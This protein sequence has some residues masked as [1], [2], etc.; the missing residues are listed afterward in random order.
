MQK[1]DKYFKG[2]SYVYHL[3]GLAKIV[4]VLKTQ[5]NIS[6]IIHLGL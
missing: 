2:V 5:E 1:L 6:L 4:Q 3:A